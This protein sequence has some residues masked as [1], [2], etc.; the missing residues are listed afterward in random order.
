MA[1][2]DREQLG[3]LLSGYIDGELDAREREIIE[4]VLRE[5]TYDYRGCS[6]GTRQARP[7]GGSGSLTHYHP[8]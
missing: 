1:R 5:E 4:R 7:P 2:I 6:I 8:V 3:E